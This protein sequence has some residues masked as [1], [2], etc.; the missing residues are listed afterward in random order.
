[1]YK[2]IL[3][4]L[5]GSATS[6]RGLSEAIALAQALQSH[7]VLLH[8]VEPAPFLAEASVAFSREVLSESMHQFGQTLLERAKAR[9]EA[10]GLTVETEMRDADGRVAT[11]LAKAAA[12][13]DCGLVVMGTHGRRGA[14]RLVMGSD[15]E[16]CVRTSP[17]PVLL[18]QGAAPA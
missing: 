9:A 11:T 2:R 15:A 18:V 17:V 7:L 6:D 12:A 5:D 14:S 8:V 16:L 4:P 10:A 13:R 3:V 1:M